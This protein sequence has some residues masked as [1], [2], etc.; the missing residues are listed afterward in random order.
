MKTRIKKRALG[1][2]AFALILVISLTLAL[3]SAAFLSSATFS[4]DETT[5]A[6]I[7]SDSSQ[8]VD[9]YITGDGVT[10]DETTGRY[11]I[12]V[13]T[14]VEITVVNNL[15]VSTALSVDGQQQSSPNFATVNVGESPIQI[16]VSAELSS[17]R[18]TSLST[19]YPISDSYDLKALSKILAATSSD[20][21]A[22]TAATFANYLAAFG[23]DNSEWYNEEGAFAGNA[24]DVWTAVNNSQS[25]LSKAYFR[26]ID[27]IM[28]NESTDTAASYQNGYF[29]IGSRRSEP[30]CGVFDFNGHAVTMNVVVSETNDV[31]FTEV[32]TT[33]KQSILS[34]G[35]FNIIE[36]NGVNA[37]AILGADVRGTIAVSS[38]VSASAKDYRLYVG[39]VAGTIGDHVI[40]DGVSSRA[41]INVTASASTD[42]AG[43]TVYAGGVFGLSAADVDSWS[44]VSY[45]GNYSEISVSNASRNNKSDT[46]VGGL[47]GVIQNSYVNGFTAT[48][49]GANILA[50]STDK[51]SAVAGGLAG[52]AYSTENVSN[53]ETFSSRE[54]T[55]VS[56]IN[57]NASGSTI[58]ALSAATT[59]SHNDKIEVGN[60]MNKTYDVAVS[61]GVLGLIYS[62]SHGALNI[63]D[64]NFNKA[65]GATGALDIRSAL[66]DSSSYGIPFAGGVFGM[67]LKDEGDV[68][69]F[70]NSLSSSSEGKTVFNCDV[71]VNSVQNGT[72]PVYAG[73]IFGY[74]AFELPNDET[75]LTFNLNGKDNTISVTAEQAETAGTVNHA[76]QYDVAAGFYTSVLQTGYSVKN[77]NF[78]VNGGTVLARRLTGSAA[79]GDI[80]AGSIAGKAVGNGSGD[81][82][83][84][85]LTVTLNSCSINALGYSFQSYE[86]TNEGNNVYAGGLIGYVSNYGSGTTYKLSS[87]KLNFRGSSDYAVR[88][89]QNAQSGNADYHGEGY[90]GGM[91]GMMHGGAA[92]GLMVKGDT[93]DSALVYF[94]STHNPNTSCVGGLIGAT[95]VYNNNYYNTVSYNIKNSTVSNLHVAGRAYTDV[96]Q[97]NLSSK[98]DLF[99]GGAI[100]VAGIAV[101]A[102]LTHD[103][104]YITVENTAIE[105]VGEKNM[106]TYAGGVIGGAWWEKNI[107][108]SNIYSNGNSVLASS[109]SYNTYA[110]GAIGQMEGTS[111]ITFS[112][113]IVLNTTVEAITYSKDHNAYAAG[114]C[115]R[116]MGNT[117]VN[118]SI[119]NAIVSASKNNGAGVVAGI[120]IKNNANTRVG[121][122]NYFVAA[123][124]NTSI[125]SAYAVIYEN[126]SGHLSG[127]NYAIALTG[128]GKDVTKN[129]TTSY[130]LDVGNSTYIYSVYSYYNYS[131]ITFSG[132]SVKIVGDSVTGS[133]DNYRVTASKQGTSYAQLWVTVPGFE[134]T[135]SEELLCSYPI[136]VVTDSIS[137]GVTVTTPDFE[138]NGKPA[139]VNGNN[140]HNFYS[141][142]FKSTAID[143]SQL[144]EKSFDR[145]IIPLDGTIFTLHTG[146]D[147]ASVRYNEAQSS[148]KDNHLYIEN[149][150]KHNSSGFAGG[151]L[152]FTASQSCTLSIDAITNNNGSEIYYLLYKNDGTFVS[153]SETNASK[154]R[155]VWEISIPSAGT[156]YV[157]FYGNSH[158]IFSIELSYDDSSMHEAVDG[159]TYFQIYAGETQMVQNVTIS[160]R[161]VYM[162]QLFL[163]TDNLYG[164]SE[165]ALTITDTEL[166]SKFIDNIGTSLPLNN[167]TLRQFFNVSTTSDG[168][169]LNISPVLGNTAGAAVIVRCDSGNGRYYYIIIEVVPNSVQF[170]T[171][172]PAEDTPARAEYED[173]YD[174][175]LRYVYAPGDTVRL[176]AYINYLFDFNR[177]I[178]D[179]SYNGDLSSGTGSVTVQP[180]GTVVIGNDVSSDSVITITCTEI[181]GNVN[182][183]STITLVVRSAITV[184]PETMT[185]AAYSP[186]K[187]NNAVVGHSFAFNLDPNPGY[188]LNP[189]LSFSVIHGG[190]DLWVVNFPEERVSADAVETVISGSVYVYGSQG[191]YVIISNG[192]LNY[193]PS[194]TIPENALKLEYIYDTV[195]GRYTITLPA[196]VFTIS[197]LS[198]IK[199][200]A[201]FNRVYSLMFDIGEWV[202][203]NAS[204][205]EALGVRYFTYKVKAE[206]ALNNDLRDEIY[207]ELKK[208]FDGVYARMG[209]TFMGFYTT[210]YTSSISAYGESFYDTCNKG[211]EQVHGAINYY[212]RWN[213]TVVLNAPSGIGIESAL[214]SNLIDREA[215]EGKNNML[216][217]IDTAHGFSF[218]I[219]GQYA[220]LPRVNVYTVNA[221]NTLT[222]LA[223][224]LA[225]GVYTIVNPDDITGTIYVYIYGDNIA[226][227]V[228]EEDNDSVFA[229]SISLRKDGIFTVRY[230]INY[231]KEQEGLSKNAVFNLGTSLPAGTAVRLFYQV[232]GVPVSVS[233]YVLS[234]DSS[235]LEINNFSPLAGSGKIA[236]SVNASSEV[237]YLVITLPNNKDNFAASNLSVSVSTLNNA[238][239]PTVNLVETTYSTVGM[240]I[241]IPSEGEDTQ[242]QNKVQDASLAEDQIL[243]SISSEVN[244]YG[245]V[246]RSGNIS[247]NKLIFTATDTSSGD[248][249]TDIRHN[250]KYY[251]WRIEGSNLS[252]LQVSGATTIT[253][254]TAVY[255]VI[256]DSSVPS[257]E[258]EVTTGITSDLEVSLMEVTNPQYPAA[259]TVVIYIVQ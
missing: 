177:Y 218:R 214:S 6:E 192:V 19:A 70:S 119:S 132:S 232:N 251:V 115:G 241:S 109:A 73:G 156:Y 23:Q 123:N 49:A 204:D 240:P 219:T 200:S 179:V 51:G 215:N 164:Y 25:T 147:G 112:E 183:S 122:G 258:I 116:S 180:N 149:N 59:N 32:G 87:I 188:G 206:T 69:Y 217:P 120:S 67:V 157:G 175:T 235:S 78:N 37:C 230:A 79:V 257:K 225:N 186:V 10:K 185:G 84:S 16:K 8:G 17:E 98:H 22:D 86:A 151:Y 31:N 254:D 36:G 75:E 71:T 136:K 210:N 47:A 187:N 155:T 205:T 60:I 62:L 9:V 35:F 58:S 94:S 189:K 198:E 97:D 100:G 208:A 48:L 126:G 166:K 118:N 165:T 39:G 168:K 4:A 201:E 54:L 141:S 13:N 191:E 55:T 145:K 212:A 133:S 56:H 150:F 216:I 159:I 81:A 7:T 244:L 34:V 224:S 199:V 80:S 65:Q 42:G 41:S 140:S 172:K 110:G 130:D 30:F 129:G 105:S 223:V 162:P 226:V 152:E 161:N 88:G 181:N 160:D 77:F 107:A 18:G 178:V 229:S 222:E 167:S 249:P 245:A 66:A 117:T 63:T 68:N 227:A 91:F 93:R 28:L 38:E 99:V 95:R 52:V 213:Y 11:N 242:Y 128:S 113:A 43:I 202:Q 246:I 96:N 12:P 26:L 237:Y 134:G 45:I 127:N 221:E 104:S 44:D 21:T 29:G 247:D 170:I 114:I 135:S 190:T 196:E 248:A 252:D 90:V 108:I 121:S 238:S 20:I 5:Y 3:Y 33:V 184:T 82:E 27:E 211:T 2:V 72:G 137:T 253:T 243:T 193:N 138:L 83:I 14:T 163:I 101:S 40:L 74:H 236:D 148:S 256:G 15:T 176:E 1:I 158:C 131:Q 250:G 103:I 125:D 195:S 53:A 61:G 76:N 239:T 24:N 194:D 255:I 111:T 50:D 85:G 233:E 154:V 57:I 143:F 89:V 102:N 144:K 146:N 64:V 197:G 207:A 259:G 209:F 203:G 124:I 139:Y 142:A 220:G 92:T 46:I 228:G 234:S 153:G 173:P 171:V 231:G 174:N 106:L 169:S 182:T